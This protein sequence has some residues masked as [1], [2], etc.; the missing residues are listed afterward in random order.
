VLR[1]RQIISAADVRFRIDFEQLSLEGPLDGPRRFGRRMED[2]GQLEWMA[3]AGWSPML[4]VSHEGPLWLDPTIAAVFNPHSANG[5]SRFRLVYGCSAE[6]H[7]AH[8]R[9]GMIA[10]VEPGKR[11]SLGWTAKKAG[12]LPPAPCCLK[13]HKSKQQPQVQ[14][15]CRRNGT[16]REQ[17]QQ[18]FVEEWRQR[19]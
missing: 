6:R 9:W 13:P 16:P 19:P 18:R 11:R 17:D 10:A 7:P 5:A 3:C 1:G 8:G 12:L 4:D 2:L 15:R 14:A